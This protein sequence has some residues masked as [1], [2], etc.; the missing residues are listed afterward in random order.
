[1]EKAREKVRLVRRAGQ[2]ARAGVWSNGRAFGNLTPVSPNGSGA[3]WHRH[4]AWH[5]PVAGLEYEGTGFLC[6]AAS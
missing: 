4:G 6:R 1:M 3:S 2:P 5:A